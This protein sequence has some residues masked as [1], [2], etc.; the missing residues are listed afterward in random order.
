MDG[1]ERTLYRLPALVEAV[2]ANQLVVV[3][4]GEA[5]VDALYTIGVAATTNSGGAG[6]WEP[7][8]NEHLC[9]ADVV[10]LPDADQIGWKH[11]TEI[12]ASLAGIAARIRVVVLPDLPA[13]GDVKDWLAAGGTREQ[14]DILV[15]AAQDWQSSTEEPP[16]D[17]AKKT[18]EAGEQALIDELSKLNPIA[19]DQRRNEAADQI[20]HPPRD[21][22][23]P[24]QRAPYAA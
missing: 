3:V 2:A 6:K 12:A 14:F 21:A 20:R 19:Y 11:A 13:K 22:R 16:S 5:C 4:E 17:E 1:V 23:Q 7:D 10:L 8:F 9:G 15:E 18:A 24:G